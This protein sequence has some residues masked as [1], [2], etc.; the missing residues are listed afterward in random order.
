MSRWRALPCVLAL[1]LA[2]CPAVPSEPPPPATKAEIAPAPPRA[3]GA[4]AAGTDAAPRPEVGPRGP[5]LPRPPLP[6]EAEAAPD[7]GAPVPNGEP[8]APDPADA[9]MAL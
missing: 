7:A 8:P 3:R 2:G 1:G 4:L 9:G 6:P 5:L